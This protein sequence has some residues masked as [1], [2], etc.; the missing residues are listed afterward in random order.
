MY[1]AQSWAET[2]LLRSAVD[3]TPRWHPGP[4]GRDRWPWPQDRWQTSN[5]Q[6]DLSRDGH[7]DYPKGGGAL[8]PCHQGSG[9]QY[10]S[11]T[12]VL[13]PDGPHSYTPRSSQSRHFLPIVGSFGQLQ[14]GDVASN[15][16]CFRIGPPHRNVSACSLSSALGFVLSLRSRRELES[17]SGWSRPFHPGW[18]TRSTPSTTEVQAELASI[19]EVPEVAQPSPTT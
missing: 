2:K 5:F 9:R 14:K 12:S 10:P 4:W 1:V 7:G 17:W 8:S 6:E 13:A 16:I 18:S 15:G 19:G 11:E 3:P